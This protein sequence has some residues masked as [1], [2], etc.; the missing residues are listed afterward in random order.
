M[1][2]HQS[3]SLLACPG[4][5]A[6]TCLNTLGIETKQLIRNFYGCLTNRKQELGNDLSVCVS[7]LQLR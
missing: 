5:A 4:A 3:E 6:R 1:L 2:T 7:N